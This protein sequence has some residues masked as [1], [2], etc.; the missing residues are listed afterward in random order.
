MPGETV[1][2]TLHTEVTPSSLIL[3]LIV[4]GFLVFCAHML[5]KRVVR[6]AEDRGY[7]EGF[8]ACVGF[9]TDNLIEE[10]YENFDDIVNPPFGIHPDDY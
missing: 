3:G 1:L 6:D 9:N 2:F 10:I 4:A 7:K 8:E 5:I